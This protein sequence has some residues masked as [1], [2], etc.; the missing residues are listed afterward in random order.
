MYRGWRHNPC[1]IHQ[2]EHS[3]LPVHCHRTLPLPIPFTFSRK[4]NPKTSLSNSL[5]TAYQ[6]IWTPET[7]W[8]LRFE[9]KHQYFKRRA[10]N[11]FNFKNLYFTLA[12]HHQLRHLTSVDV[13][14]QDEYT[15]KQCSRPVRSLSLF[16]P[17]T[18]IRCRKH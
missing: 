8:C 6:T 16:R 17:C 9:A 11:T 7:I 4:I 1:S 5:H 14:R 15:E 3:S 12:K 18:E 10:R 2:E 13:L